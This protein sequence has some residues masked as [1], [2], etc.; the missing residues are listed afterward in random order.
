[1]DHNI[2]VTI[3][4]ISYNHE[5]YIADAIESFLMQKV[6]FNYE[7]LIHD[8][9]ST[10]KTQ[11]IIMEYTMKYPNIIKPI[12]QDENQYSKGKK[13]GMFHKD[14]AKGKYIAICEG[15]DYW[16]DTNKLQKQIDYLENHPECSMC[17]HASY[18]VKPNKK[19]KIKQ[20]G[21]ASCRETV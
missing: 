6:S 8:Y 16:T 17:V 14:I 20:I 18:R 10:D 4:C 19:K 5:N 9:A 3:S 13:V 15:D 2:L 12:L 11:D 7:I 1:M 21:R